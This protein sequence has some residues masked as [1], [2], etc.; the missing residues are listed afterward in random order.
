MLGRRHI[1]I[2]I[3]TT[4]VGEESVDK[5]SLDFSARIRLPLGRNLDVVAFHGQ[6]MLEGYDARD[7]GT[8]YVKLKGT[9]YG[10]DMVGHLL[11]GRR[12][13]PFVSAGV[14]NVTADTIVDGRPT[15]ADEDVK[16]K[17]GGGVE[18]NPWKRVS[19]SVGLTYQD[20]FRDSYDSDLSAGISLDGW[21]NDILLISLVAEGSFDSR[22]VSA[23]VRAAYGF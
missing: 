7:Q 1:G 4:W 12:A 20:S 18:I 19:L 22:D 5:T 6:S 2:G 13:D 21:L 9:E 11:P 15:Y 8:P 14:S 3:G 23:S 16:F 17:V 10:V